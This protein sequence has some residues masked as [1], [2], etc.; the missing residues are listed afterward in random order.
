MKDGV[1]NGF[2]RNT[3]RGETLEKLTLSICAVVFGTV[4]TCLC[5]W[6]ETATPGCASINLNCNSILRG[7]HASSASRKATYFPSALSQPALRALAAPALVFS[8]TSLI[9]PGLYLLCSC[10]IKD[11]VS[12]PLPSSTRMTSV[13]KHVC[14]AIDATARAS[15]LVQR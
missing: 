7:C 5:P 6:P 15:V 12:S 2:F 13:G 9:Q 8:S 3:Y 11:R 14:S 4:V 1:T 10:V